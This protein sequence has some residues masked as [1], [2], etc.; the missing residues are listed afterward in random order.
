MDRT[1]DRSRSG[2]AGG[3]SYPTVK[4]IESLLDAAADVRSSRAVTT[5]FPRLRNLREVEATPAV[6]G[7][8]A[9]TRLPL[10][11]TTTPVS[12]EVVAVSVT[13]SPTLGAV[14][15]AARLVVVGAR[16][17]DLRTIVV[18]PEPP[19]LMATTSQSTGTPLG[20]VMSNSRAVV[21]VA[22]TGFPQIT[23]YP[24]GS[25]PPFEAGGC[26]AR[27]S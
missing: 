14:V 18:G 12:A 15:L 13:R 10:E 25:G 3:C 6:T 9:T 20:A 8:R 4:V 16:G 11:N 2:Q 27:W 19:A 21:V 22:W 23:R 26:Q 24:E 7:Q 5:W 1:Q 17:V